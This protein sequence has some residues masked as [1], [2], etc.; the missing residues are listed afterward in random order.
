[1]EFEQLRHFLKVAELG[2]FTRAAAEIGLSQSALSRSIARLE[3]DLGQP[4]F[5]RQVRQVTLTDAG[6]L[7][8]ARAERIL[9]LVED[10]RAE[11]IDDDTTSTLRVGAIPTIAPFFLPGLLRQFAKDFPQAH[12]IVQED[13]TKNLLDR[14]SHGE[15]DLAILAL[16]VSVKYLEVLELF[17]EELLLVLP[18]HHPLAEK[19]QIRPTDIEP[20]PFVLLSE[21][22]CLSGNIAS[23]CRQKSFQP[24]SVERTSQL[25]TVQE[26]VSLNH[27]V[28]MI[29]AMARDID[30]TNRRVYRSLAGERPTRKIALVWNSYRYQ[31]KLFGHFKDRLVA[32]SAK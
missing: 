9:A 18:L 8:K 19:K 15:I 22:H 20:L 29:P 30:R 5:E 13:T 28:S 17:E 10:T 6:Q 32:Y 25:T 12:V 21:A 7:L 3:T 11:I 24:V 23:F 14:C 1:M 16:P 4:L 2:N 26:L 27:G 31:S